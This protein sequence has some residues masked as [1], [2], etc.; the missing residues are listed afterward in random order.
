MP[1]YYVVTLGCKLNQFDSARAEGILRGGEYVATD[2]PARAD[3]ILLNTCT[4]TA[5]ADA[6]GR[7]LARQLR[8]LNPAARIVAT[9]CYAERDPEALRRLGVVDAV[10]GLRDRARLPEAL[11]GDDECVTAPASLFFG[12]RARAFLRVQEG[13]DLACSYCVIPQVRGPSRSVGAAE[14]VAQAADLA[15]CGVREIGL[16]G[17]NVGAWGH[18]LEPRRDLA[19][20]LREMLAA[21]PGPRI[22]LNSL[23]PRTVGAPLV[24]LLAREPGRLAPHVQVPLQSGSDHVLG[25]M[26][27]NYRTRF[28]A[29][30]VERLVARVPDICVGAD[31]IAG[32][33]GETE[34]DHRAT[35]AFVGSLPLAYL[36][37]FSYSPRPGTRAAAFGAPVPAPEARRRTAELRAVGARLRRAFRERM[38]GRR[39]DALVLHAQSGDGWART[40]TGNYIE[41][42]VPRAPAGEIVPVRLAAVEDDGETVRGEVAA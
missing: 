23:E 4:V 25:R 21:D 39:L 14:I 16:T 26:S 36:H 7:R 31:V 20:L 12:D 42:L 10:V 40:L 19:A 11:L 3:V 5:R 8:R 2:D 34:D 37:V 35:L 22:R 24:E 38:L 27:R 6:E 17:V 18:D 33:P 13:C 28:Y 41:V 29:E 32:F 30:L 9:G 1:A 15:R